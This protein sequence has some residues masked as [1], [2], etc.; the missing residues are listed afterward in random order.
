MQLDCVQLERRR[1]HTVLT[2]KVANLSQFLR[3]SVFASIAH[4][5]ALYERR[6]R[7]L[8]GIA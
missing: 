3:Q 7:F 4:I 2:Q 1:T 6:T 5:T 8:T